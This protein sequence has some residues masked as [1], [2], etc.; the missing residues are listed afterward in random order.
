[1]F[2]IGHGKNILGSKSLVQ[3]EIIREELLCSVSRLE[4]A[5][6]QNKAMSTICYS[7]T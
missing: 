4:D 7:S 5:F 6:L 3:A 1:M 2:V